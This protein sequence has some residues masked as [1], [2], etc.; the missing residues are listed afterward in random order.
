MKLSYLDLDNINDLHSY[1]FQTVDSKRSFLSPMMADVDSI[2][3]L[4]STARI[5]KANMQDKVIAAKREKQ[6]ERDTRKRRCIFIIM[7]I[8]ITG[9]VVVGCLLFTS[10]PSNMTTTPSTTHS[11]KTTTPSTTMATTTASPSTTTTTPSTTTA[12]L[13]T[14][15]T[16]LSTTTT[17]SGKF[18]PLSYHRKI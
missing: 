9:I 17:T 5:V 13:S 3:L 10:V 7:C 11:T 2:P 1:I 8:M 18:F 16:T 6:E 4:D 14:T 15:T 12:T